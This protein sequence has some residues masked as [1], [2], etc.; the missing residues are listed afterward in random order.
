MISN[1]APTVIALSATLKAGHDQ[2]AVVEQQEIDDL[3]DGDAVPQIA[4][5][6]AQD[7]RKSGADT[8]LPPRFSM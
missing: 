7:Q 5:R 2:L 3:A 4:Q 8:R 6:A 1:A